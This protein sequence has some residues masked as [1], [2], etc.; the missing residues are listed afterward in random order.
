MT[1]APQHAIAFTLSLKQGVS[2]E[3]LDAL[4]SYHQIR[5]EKTEGFYACIACEKHEDGRIH[6]HGFQLFALPRRPDNQHNSLMAIPTLRA[7]VVN[8]DNI[9]K[10]AL[11]CKA[12]PSTQFLSYCDKDTKDGLEQ[13]LLPDDF[14]K[15][16]AYFPD[17]FKSRERDINPDFTRWA[18]WYEEEGFALPATLQR[19]EIF[20]NKMM[21]Q[22]NR[23]RVQEDKR[24]FENRLDALVSFINKDS[25]LRVCEKRAT[26]KNKVAVC[27]RCGCTE[28]NCLATNCNLAFNF[29]KSRTEIATQTD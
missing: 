5:H 25:P 18:K 24:K 16:K 23:I 10:I 20:L 3:V 7:A 21:F 1:P 29:K 12:M 19:V 9:P 13:D 2:K 17:Y 26:Y 4:K 22:D 8:G 6:L 11:K 14:E 15:V 27:F 28:E